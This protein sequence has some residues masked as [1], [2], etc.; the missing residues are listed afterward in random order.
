MVDCSP[1]KVWSDGLKSPSPEGASQ[2]QSALTE[3]D[4]SGLERKKS[5]VAWLGCVSV[6]CGMA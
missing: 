3:R 5:L 2:D 4:G 1:R 6:S